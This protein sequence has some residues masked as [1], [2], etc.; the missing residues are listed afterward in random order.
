M[1]LRWQTTKVLIRKGL[2]E[3]LYRSS[4]SRMCHKGKV[5]ILT[6]HRVVPPDELADHWIQPG[7]YVLHDVFA[8][9]MEFLRDQFHVISML[10]LMER[11]RHSDWDHK[12]QYCV[13][14]FDDGWLDNYRYAYPILRKF[15]IS[16][17][18]FLPTDFVGTHEWFWPE[19][20]AY[21]VK[22]MT[23][24]EEVCRKGVAIL[25]KYIDI[26][27]H[28]ARLACGSEDAGRD[29]ADQVIEH[30]KSLG[31]ETI[32]ELIETV[33][34]ELAIS[35]PRERC[36]LNWD[37]VAQ[38]AQGGVS[39]GSHS[40]SHRILTQ[41]SLDDVRE[42]LKGSQQVLKSRIK[43][44]VP[45]LCYPNGNTNSKI[46]AVA[47]DCGYSAAVGVRPGFEGKRPGRLFDLH[48]ISIHNDIAATVPL[49]SMRL[50]A[51]SIV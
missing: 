42:E 16:A 9:H 21:C 11:W 32:S 44:Y 34:R 31:Q 1:G 20:V 28:P 5:A 12:A 22:G 36:I 43:S 48:R 35:P 39:F 23:A 13:V 51:P 14:T 25:K 10:E 4:L 19:K 33:C 3:L 17:T 47:K 6:Y 46:E 41:L 37:E 26:G 45:V 38:M 49:Y 7:M 29:F 15:E 8:R 24:G 40:R 30:C 2:A 50:C 18:I 27:Q